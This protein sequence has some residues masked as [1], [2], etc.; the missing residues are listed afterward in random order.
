YYL[1]HGLYDDSIDLTINSVVIED[2]YV[3][4]SGAGIRL[5]TDQG[6]SINAKIY[7]SIIRNNQATIRGGGIYAR[8]CGG[9]SS[10]ELLVVNC[11]I[12]GNQADWAAGGIDLIA[13]NDNDTV[14][15]TIINSTISENWLNDPQENYSGQGAGIN[16]SSFQGN[17]ADVSLGLFNTIVYGNTLPG[18]VVQDLCIGEEE[19]GSAAVNAS[20]CDIGDVLIV[21]GIPFYDSSRVINANP[22]FVNPAVGDYHLTPES[23]CIETGTSWLNI[24]LPQ[25]DIEGNPRIIGL[26]PDIGAYEFTGTPAE[27]TVAYTPNSLNFVAMEG[28]SNPPV[29]TVEFWNSGAGTIQCSPFDDAPWLGS[30]PLFGLSTG[31]TDIVTLT[32][33][34]DITSMAAGDYDATITLFD[35]LASNEPL[36][37][38][39]LTINPPMQIVDEPSTADAFASIAPFLETAYGYRIGEGTGGWTVYNPSWPSELNSLTT[40]YVARGYWLNVRETCTLQ[41]GSTVIVLDQPGWWLIGW[42]PQ[43]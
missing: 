33:S 31:D 15:A 2:N 28:G 27:K 26:S 4:G 18:D 12:Y 7:N 9:G 10:V 34:V 25:T 11:L 19:P 24:P 14:Q 35:M 16:V 39:H 42:L 32:V 41:Y 22:D 29:Q 3:N 20:Y 43:T 21:D 30:S 17:G 40:L 13:C 5:D 8:A 37:P 36:I 38:V 23:P 6:D 1:G